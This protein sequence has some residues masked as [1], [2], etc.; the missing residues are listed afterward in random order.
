MTARAAGPRLLVPACWQSQ[1]KRNPPCRVD[2]IYIRQWGSTS[3]ATST[4]YQAAKSSSYLIVGRH[5]STCLVVPRD[6]LH[7]RLSQAICVY[8]MALAINAD[9]R[10][11]QYPALRPVWR[12]TCIFCVSNVLAGPIP[13]EYEGYDVEPTTSGNIVPPLA[14]DRGFFAP[15]P[16][17]DTDRC[18][19]LVRPEIANHPWAEGSLHPEIMP[20]VTYGWQL[21]SES[22]KFDFCYA[23]E[24]ETAD[25]GRLLGFNQRG[26]E[27]VTRYCNKTTLQ[28]IERSPPEL[29]GVLETV[30]RV[31]MGLRRLNAAPVHSENLEDLIF[32]CEIFLN[33]LCDCVAAPSLF[34]E[35]RLAGVPAWMRSQADPR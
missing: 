29:Q 8:T 16:S 31:H 6:S 14:T 22:I 5:I 11:R 17:Y 30:Q 12:C 18:E 28:L 26:R 13:P 7:L 27:K 33:C 34:P 15:A 23:Q 21:L 24:V 10:L 3:G 4:T 19:G 32:A 2:G 1:S 35:A 9:A 25:H 20:Q